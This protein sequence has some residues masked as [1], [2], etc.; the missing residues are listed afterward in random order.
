MI[1][2]LIILGTLLQS[3][4]LA[5]FQGVKTAELETLIKQNV[6]VIDIRTPGEWKETGT[7]P[8][9]HR[10]MFYD[11]RGHYDIQKWMEAFGKVV[12]DKEQPFVLVCRSASRTKVVGRFLANQ[13][14]YK[15]VK[16]LDGGMMWGWLN[17]HKPVE[18]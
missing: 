10:I 16:E 14:G 18:K 3:L 1:K 7:I 8:G 2:R 9:S 6:P 17:S 13:M 12:K 5:D 15:H 4:L 11:D